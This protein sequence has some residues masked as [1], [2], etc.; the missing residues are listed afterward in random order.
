M[1]LLLLI[2]GLLAG[3]YFSQG[4]EPADSTTGTTLASTTV[5]TTAEP[6]TEATTE[7]TTIPVETE[8]YITATASVGVSGDILL[9]TGLHASAKNGSEYDFSD[10]FKFIEE[11]YNRYDFM[12]ANLEVP[13]AGKDKG[14][15]G[16]PLFNS[17]DAIATDMKE[18]GMD[19][20]LTANNHAI[21]KGHDGLIRTQEVLTE[22]GLQYLGTQMSEDAPDYIVQDI[23]GIQVG[24]V[25]YTY[26]TGDTKEGLK[27][28]NGNVVPKKSTDLVTSFNPK[29]LDEFYAEVVETLHQMR[30]AGAE[31]TMLFIHWGNEYE[32]KQNKTQTAIAQQL[33]ELGVDV[34][35]GGHPHVIQPFE[36]LVSSTGHETYCI[37]SVGN[38]LSN[39]NRNSL[40]N[41]ANS[42]YTEDG[43]IFG[44]TF[45]KWND[46]TVNI[47]E[48][49]IMPTWVN[50]YQGASKR[51]YYIMPLD[52]EL[53]S[54]N[55]FDAKNLNYTYGSYRRTLSIVGPGLNAYR[56]AANLQPLPLEKEK[57]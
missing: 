39:Q 22:A 2:V 27:T 4:S 46:G 10:M 56:E 5:S 43:M 41:T 50:V 57:N 40:P 3:I 38:A 52:I 25:C 35:V 17:P 45:E 32:L 49:T 48:I 26:E 54:W 7:P 47:Q 8:P 11:Y 36:V 23:N 51:L 18:A 34:I 30:D 44:V 37:Y 28:L 15:S 31:V 13:L 9:H 1:V 42:E 29:Q 20:V 21:D 16:Y 14:Y 6:T 33:C 55:D 53:E 12:V 19:M 24:M